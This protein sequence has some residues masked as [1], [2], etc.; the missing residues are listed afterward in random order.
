MLSPRV[1]PPGKQIVERF[2]ARRLQLATRQPV[3]LPNGRRGRIFSP[4][5]IQIPLE[6]LTKITKFGRIFSPDLATF[7]TR[8][9]TNST[10]IAH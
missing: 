9:Y 6:F 2:G 4:D 7:L 1:L 5:F 10:R 8:F 3:Q